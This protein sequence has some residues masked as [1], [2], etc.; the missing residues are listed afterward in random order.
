[1]FTTRLQSPF[2]VRRRRRLQRD[3]SHRSPFTV[4]RRVSPFVVIVAT[5]ASIHVLQSSFLT[6]HRRLQCDFNPS[7]DS[8]HCKSSPSMESLSQL[9][10]RLQHLHLEQS[11]RPVRVQIDRMYSYR[12]EREKGRCHHRSRSIFQCQGNADPPVLLLDVCTATSI[13]RR[14][15]R[16]F[17]RLSLL[18][19]HSQRLRNVAYSRDAPVRLVLR[20]TTTAATVLLLL[21][22]LF[23]LQP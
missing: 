11:R 6:T 10:E 23:A 7:I 17:L 14:F 22:P 3:F 2:A 9:V 19:L 16:S 13:R 15:F 18:H 5:R 20:R 12:R 4:D 21:P 1:M 8:I